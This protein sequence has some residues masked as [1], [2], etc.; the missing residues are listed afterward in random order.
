[1][2]Y[3]NIYIYNIFMIIYVDFPHHHRASF[4][5][6]DK[7]DINSNQKKLSL[8]PEKSLGLEEPGGWYGL[9]LHLE[10]SSC[11]PEVSENPCSN[12]ML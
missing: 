7:V 4:I 1:M 12:L 9:L 10:C 3:I 2:I 5:F 11:F 8:D 6:A